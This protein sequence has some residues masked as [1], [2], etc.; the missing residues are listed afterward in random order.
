MRHPSFHACSR[1]TQKIRQARIIAL[2]AIQTPRA[3]KKKGAAA[4][5]R[6]RLKES[7]SG[8]LK[9]KSSGRNV[10]QPECAARRH[11]FYRVFLTRKF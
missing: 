4:H 8:A 6:Q 9:W 2:I 11:S 5:T 1:T 10:R 3:N 7:R